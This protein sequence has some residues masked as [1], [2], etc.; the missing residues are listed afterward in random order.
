MATRKRS[1]AAV[2]RR[3]GW[4]AAAI[5]EGK[6][7]NLARSYAGEDVGDIPGKLLTSV[8]GAPLTLAFQ[9]MST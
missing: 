6:F 9:R 8:V 5:F 1:L 3:Y 4:S 7:S 2:L